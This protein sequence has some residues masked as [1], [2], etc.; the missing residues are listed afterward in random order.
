[1]DY[2][3]IFLLLTIIAGTTMCKVYYVVL[4]LETPCKD[5]PCITLKQF[6]SN[7]SLY[8]DTTNTTLVLEPGNHMLS[9]DS[10]I[11]NISQL[12]IVSGSSSMPT[13]T[14]SMSAKTGFINI[15]QVHIRGIRFTGC[16]KNLFNFIILTNATFMNHL[17][18]SSSTALQLTQ[19][20]VTVA[21]VQC[22]FINLVG[23]FQNISIILSGASY[24]TNMVHQIIQVMAEQ[25]CHFKVNSS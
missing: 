13:I 5:D 1:M 7:F 23:I 24:T 11:S 9:V 21:I 8:I 19:T 2:H 20:V 17:G 3:F 15:T 18:H 16:G 6:I 12:A 22:S 25:L 14:C 10:M 4:S